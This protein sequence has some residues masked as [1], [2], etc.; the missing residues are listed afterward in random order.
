MARERLLAL[1][2]DEPDIEVVATASSGPDAVEAVR[3][4][5][6]DLIFLDMQMPDLDGLGVVEA[7]GAD[8]MPATIFVTA[9]DEYAVQAFEVHALDYLLKPFGR[10]RFQ[11]AIARAREHM[12][13]DRAG[14]LAGRLVR[15]I[16]EMRAPAA[17]GDRVMV[18]DSGRVVF[19]DVEHIDWIEAEGNYVRIHT[20]SQS[21]LLRE[22]MA[23]LQ[24]RVGAQRFFRIHRS[25][26]VNVARIKEL[27]LAAGGD[28]DVIL[29]NGVKLGLSRLY[30]DALQ[31]RLA[32]GR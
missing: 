7:I 6:P 17:S 19:I 3:R 20:Q 2:A 4:L 30:K 1:L 11:K 5:G 12:E 23:N 16:E 9:F 27:H 31:E 32:R 18:R 22:T 13:R 10:A 29:E 24:L 15:L 26:I 25:R 14:A 21:H 8:R 28:Y